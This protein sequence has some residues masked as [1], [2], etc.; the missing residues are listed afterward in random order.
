MFFWF[1]DLA[2]LRKKRKD[3]V[4]YLCSS[5]QSYSETLNNMILMLKAKQM[6][7]KCFY[8][9]TIKTFSW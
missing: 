6:F 3:L 5:P 2:F 1:S 7:L 9:N 4:V 8:D